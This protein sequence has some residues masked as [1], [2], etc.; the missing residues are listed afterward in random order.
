MSTENATVNATVNETVNATIEASKTI[1]GVK[2]TA[3][4][5]ESMEVV[6]KESVENE[7]AMP[8]FFIEDNAKNRITVDILYNK[9]TGKLL[10]ITKAGLGL[11]FSAYSEFGYSQE[12]FE[13]TQPDYEDLCSYRQRCS[14]YNKEAKQVLLDGVQLR[15]FLLVWHLKDWSLKDKTGKKI[16]LKHDTS[17]SLADESM[18]QV[19]SVLPTLID[20]VM[21]IFEKEILLT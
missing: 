6:K 14:T 16:E 1:E 8:L 4:D 10:S 7:N 3:V 19:Y 5:K 21:T 20:V 2:V 15:Q 9:K 11:D 17:G 13:F 18:K 12:W